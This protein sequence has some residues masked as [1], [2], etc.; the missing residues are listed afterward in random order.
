MEDV[1]KQ[2][3]PHIFAIAD[4]AY[5]SMVNHGRPWWTH[6]KKFTETRAKPQ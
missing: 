1:F 6:P 3:P 4:G 2:V 5:Q